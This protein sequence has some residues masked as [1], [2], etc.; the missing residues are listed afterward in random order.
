MQD[1]V[2]VLRAL[3]LSRPRRVQN[4]SLEPEVSEEALAA[5]KQSCVRRPD[6]P[7]FL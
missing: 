1:S 6:S 3:K 2:Q 4:V 5:S 7:Y